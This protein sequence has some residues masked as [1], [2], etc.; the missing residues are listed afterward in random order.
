VVDTP[1]QTEI[2]EPPWRKSKRKR[3]EAWPPLDREAVVGAA[4]RVL[5]REGI[6][7]LS[8]R[9]VAEELGTGPA[10][11]YWHVRNKEELLDLVLDQVIGEIHLPA[12]DPSRWQEQGKAFMREA[13]TVL[14]RHPG[15]ARLTLGRIPTG[16]N[17]LR[18]AEWQ[19]ALLRGAGIPDRV[20]AFAGDLFGLYLGAYGFEES[21][22]APSATDEQGEPQD[23]EKML[24]DY[25]S[26]LPTDRFPNLTSL[27][28]LLFSGDR[29]ERFEFG[30]DVL[31][32]GLEAAA[33]RSRS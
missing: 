4:V 29:D 15:A 1:T 30:L 7:G 5:D 19:L 14:Q 12:P 23:V 27:V 16:P 2:P 21:L 9:R 13:R 3:G 8:M 10:S 20:A 31:F 11:L 18:A 28:D 22:G 24:R 6:E 25:W 33:A 17:A 26:S 32:A